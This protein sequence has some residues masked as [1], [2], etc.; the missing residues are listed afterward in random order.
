LHQVVV[1][2]ELWIL[3]QLEL[4]ALV[5]LA[6]E[7]AEAKSITLGVA[8]VFLM[9]QA[10]VAQQITQVELVLMHNQVKAV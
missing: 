2:V 6:A 3:V 5:V 7:M 10:A 1:V 9:V 8:L 4:V